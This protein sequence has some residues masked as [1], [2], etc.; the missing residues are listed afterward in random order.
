[1]NILT[2]T[3]LTGDL[4]LGKKKNYQQKNVIYKQTYH[5]NNLLLELF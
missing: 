5:S 1:M 4:I 3:A 2:N